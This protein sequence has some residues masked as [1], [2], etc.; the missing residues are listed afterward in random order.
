VKAQA[1]E[2]LK[3]A[4]TGKCRQLLPQMF[5]GDPVLAGLGGK[6]LPLRPH[7]TPKTLMKI[8]FAPF[9]AANPTNVI[10]L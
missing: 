10:N 4:Q 7:F 6:I 5:P 8:R 1:R 2:N 3:C 9:I